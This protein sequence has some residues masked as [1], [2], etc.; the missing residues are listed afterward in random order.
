MLGFP[1]LAGEREGEGEGE[2]ERDTEGDH[3]FMLAPQT[4]YVERER[5]RER[6]KGPW[7][8]V[9]WIDDIEC[10]APTP[11]TTYLI[12]KEIKTPLFLQRIKA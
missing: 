3:E 6:D 8:W 1:N 9:G 4:W 5:E 2:G 12:A 11:P 7:E 10:Q